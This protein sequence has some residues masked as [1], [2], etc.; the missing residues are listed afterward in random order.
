[1]GVGKTTIGQ[2]LAKFL[3]IPHFDLDQIIEEKLQTSISSLFKDKGE[4]YFRKQEHL[5]LKQLLESNDPF[6]LSLGGGTPC[7]ANNH[8]LMQQD[9]VE[10]FYLKATIDTLVKRLQ[11]DKAHRPILHQDMDD[12]LEI[13][14]AKHLF[15]RSYF[16]H[17][18]KHIIPVD[19]KTIPSI[20]E[21]ITTKI[22]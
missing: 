22:D 19:H 3:N 17:Q 18:A 20:V 12:T 6:V 13:F 2:E 10:S 5:V 21:E 16:Y 1:M 11:N 14:I 8:L 15:D 4:I 7:Y 9:G